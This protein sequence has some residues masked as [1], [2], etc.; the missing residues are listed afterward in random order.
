MAWGAQPARDKLMIKLVN[1]R[2]GLGCTLLRPGTGT[3]VSNSAPEFETCVLSPFFPSSPVLTMCEKNLGGRVPIGVVL[4]W[5]TRGAT[6]DTPPH[7]YARERVV[8]VNDFADALQKKNAFCMRP[9]SLFLSFAHNLRWRVKLHPQYV[10]MYTTYG[11]NSPVFHVA[12]WSGLHS[13]LF[14]CIYTRTD[15][16]LLT[17]YNDVLQTASQEWHDL[18]V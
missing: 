8:S 14:N 7:R 13:S 16:L 2:A 4:N 12:L 10:R 1:R 18:S 6:V 9:L 11:F 17:K 15:N 3:H 5:A